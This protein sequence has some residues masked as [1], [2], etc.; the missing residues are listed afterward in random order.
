MKEK[1][2]YKCEET[3]DLEEYIME[4]TVKTYGTIIA[5]YNSGR[6]EEYRSVLLKRG[7]LSKKRAGPLSGAKCFSI[8]KISDDR[9]QLIATIPQAQPN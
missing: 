4:H 6:I 1:A 7:V 8:G 5:V 3:I 2:P 9:I